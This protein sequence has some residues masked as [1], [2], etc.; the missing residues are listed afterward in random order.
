[1]VAILSLYIVSF[2]L[3]VLGTRN[4][5]EASLTTTEVKVLLEK[6]RGDDLRIMRW[7]ASEHT[8]EQQ[9]KGG[10][11]S[12]D[13][14]LKIIATSKDE[15]LFAV[16]CE[17]AT[18]CITDNPTHRAK[19]ASHGP[20]IHSAIVEMVSSANHQTSAM[21]SH[22]IYIATF[23]NAD[24]HQGFFRADAVPR[25]AAIVK[26]S[27]KEN[28]ELTAVQVMWAAAALQNLAASYCATEDDGRCYWHFTRRH[29][30]ISITED[31][32]PLTSDGKAI[33]EEIFTF[34]LEN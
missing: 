13:D 2:L 27:K 17:Y 15:E 11:D 22:L 3:S 33:R 5:A 30:D 4:V 24:N 6:I 14:V 21:A 34:L 16:A 12:L 29:D 28:S 25:L 18:F 20:S 7:D 9:G 1:M 23:A 32:L 8:T 31:S 26:E 10:C 19:L